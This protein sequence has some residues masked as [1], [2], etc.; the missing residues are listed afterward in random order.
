MQ[1]LG[2]SVDFGGVWTNPNAVVVPNG[3]A[4]SSN[5]PGQYNFV[6]IVSN[7]VCPSDTANVVVNVQGCDYLVGL[8]DIAFEAFNMY[9]NP[10]SDVVF[11]TNSG[12]TDVFNYE[13]LDMNGRVILKANDAIKGSTNTELDL[14]QVEVGVYMIRVFNEKAEK[15]FRVVKN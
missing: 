2:G 15:T 12:S 6:Y 13:V 14:R 7:G 8:E 5:I 1:G 10:T 4:T 11:I 9:P 3:N